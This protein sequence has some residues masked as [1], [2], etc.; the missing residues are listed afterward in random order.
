M[1]ADRITAIFDNDVG[2]EIENRYYLLLNRD[3][4]TNYMRRFILTI[5]V[6]GCQKN[7]AKTVIDY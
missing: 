7:T 5:D 2:L 6:M 3:C 1:I 4:C